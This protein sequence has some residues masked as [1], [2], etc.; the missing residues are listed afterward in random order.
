MLA[1]A[2]LSGG[3]P[4]AAPPNIVLIISDDQS[5]TDYSFMGHAVIQTPHIDALAARSAT[6]RRGYVPTALCRPS[7]MTMITG[8]YPH[9][10]GVPGNDPQRSPEMSG[11]QYAQRRAALISQIDE[12]PTLPKQ[13]GELGYRSHQS[14]KWWE[15][16]WRRGGFTAGMT[17]GFPQRGGRHGDDGL[18]IGRNGL[19]P[20]FD[21][22]D[23]SVSGG[24]PF[25][26]WYAPFLP[27][28][29]HTPPDRLLG[30]YQAPGRP[31][32]LAR[33]YAMCEWFDETVG[34]LVGF[35]DDQ[36]LTEDTLVVYVTDNGWIQRTPQTDVPD[37]WRQAFAPKSKQSPNEAGIRTPIMYCWPGVIPA[38]EH[39]TLV[40]SIDIMPTLLNAAGAAL[41]DN[42]P[43]ANLLPLMT[44][45]DPPDRDFLY[46]ETF[47]HDVVDV[48]DPRSS[49]LFRWCI[50]DQWKLIL[51]YRDAGGRYSVVHSVQE[52]QPQLY[53]LGED[54]HE[55]RNVA[56]A[57][58][59]VVAR[60]A[61]HIQ[62]VWPIDI[63]PR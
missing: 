63:A 10:H 9:Q 17:R 27:H 2:V 30:K 36:N 51:S 16:N 4:L 1:A 15:G 46:G 7:L 31:V 44:G 20:V 58:P 12:L 61:G 59:E 39:D 52:R 19:Q 3:T 62:S 38:Q 18:A 53:H 21:F 55:R 25:F 28:T 54:P 14:G 33:Y 22:I 56:A 26:V 13:L 29:P 23:E 34:D 35:L 24:D 11:E 57:N 48:S 45:G 43:G 47:S 8:L 41:P 49:L 6:F 40:S 50:E 5:W 32:E 42:L 37:G 60:L